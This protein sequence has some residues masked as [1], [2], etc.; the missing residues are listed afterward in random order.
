MSDNCIEWTPEEQEIWRSTVCERKRQRS[1]AI[2]NSCLDDEQPARRKNACIRVDI[3]KKLAVNLFHHV[4]NLRQI[5][6]IHA[7]NKAMANHPVNLIRLSAMRIVVDDQSVM[8]GDQVFDLKQRVNSFNKKYSAW[9]EKAQR[10]ADVFAAE[11]AKALSSI[12]YGDSTLSPIPWYKKNVEIVVDEEA[13]LE[14]LDKMVCSA[15]EEQ[16]STLNKKKETNSL[17]KKKKYK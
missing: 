10:F 6:H 9:V 11:E 12:E 7:N 16:E 15:I 1:M 17:S 4:T 8:K 5:K 2:E 14:I 3:I 13:I